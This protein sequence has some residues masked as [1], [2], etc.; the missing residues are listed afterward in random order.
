MNLQGLLNSLSCVE[1]QKIIFFRFVESFDSH[2][3]NVTEI[4]D[5]IADDYTNADAYEVKVRAI[6]YTIKNSPLWVLLIQIG[7]SYIAYIFSKFASKVQ[8]QGFSFALPLSAVVPLSATL[9]LSACG[10]R[11]ENRCVFHDFLPD[12]LFFEC[13]SVGDYFDY[14]W[15]EQVWLWALWFMSQIWISAHIWFPK[16][17]RLA[18]T[19][20]I[21]GTP[22]Y[23]SLVIDQSLVLNRR[24][25]GHEE[26]KVQFFFF[27]NE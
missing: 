23:C 13:P 3:F 16:S 2:P 9:L 22:M 19:E 27:S 6:L 4:I 20:Q 18:S 21:F 15:Q 7:A 8:I 26:L 11:A 14:L 25:D 1:I 17:A 5:V 10:A 24:A 12:Y